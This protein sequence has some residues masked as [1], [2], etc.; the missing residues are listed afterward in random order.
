MK[1]GLIVLLMLSAFVAPPAHAQTPP[2][3]SPDTVQPPPEGFWPSRR[4]TEHTLLRWTD[5][6]V[7]DYK[8]TD[9]QAA[10]LEEMM[11]RRW[12]AWMERNRHE[13][14]PVLNEFLERR[15][16][17]EPPD[18]AEVRAWAERALRVFDS[19]KEELRA[20]QA[21]FRETLGPQQKMQFDADVAKMNVGMEL[22]QQKLSNWR[23]GHFTQRDLWDE[24]RWQRRQR[25]EAEAEAA[26]RL[27]A[28]QETAASELTPVEQARTQIDQWEQFVRDFI[29]R[30]RF[31]EAQST[32]AWAILQ[33][34]R[35][36]AEA[37]RL[38]RAEDYARIQQRMQDASTET[39]QTL[40]EEMV[41]LDVPV[42][43]LFDELRTRLAR[44]LTPAQRRAAESEP[45]T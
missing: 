3:D 19:T 24:P 35:T 38:R 11:L 8:L 43:D 23:D 27:A 5:Q 14:Q 33:D 44:L 4:M 2:A 9:D 21:E 34:V 28:E 7:H 20:A 26:R 40:L 6:I 12:P 37:Y 32:T 45:T 30:H 36:R 16:A 18:S 41:Q 42:G 25:R 13:L 39:Q 10:R 29:S 22:F 1:Y 17:P 15:L 31:D